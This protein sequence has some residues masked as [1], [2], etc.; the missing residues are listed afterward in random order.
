MHLS[1][2]VSLTLNPTVLDVGAKKAE[3]RNA[4]VNVGSVALFRVPIELEVAQ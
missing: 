3:I 2:N 1:W 4:R